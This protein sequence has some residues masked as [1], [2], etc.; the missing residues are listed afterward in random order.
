[1]YYFDVRMRVQ[2]DRSERVSTAMDREQRKNQPSA[3]WATVHI[4]NMI[5]QQDHR[6]SLMHVP[7]MHVQ[8]TV[9]RIE[10]ATLMGDVNGCKLGSIVITI[11]AL[12]E[13]IVLCDSDSGSTTWR[14][15]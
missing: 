6:I 3:A 2:R 1:M 10:K 13:P 8:Q 14:G 7:A 11:D 5:A 12:V 15:K 4:S 9:Q